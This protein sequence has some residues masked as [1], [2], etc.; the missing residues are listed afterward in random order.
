[1]SLWVRNGCTIRTKQKF[2]KIRKDNRLHMKFHSSVL[3]GIGTAILLAAS[4]PATP[5]LVLGETTFNFGAVPQNSKVSHVF[6]L[7]SA[8]EDTLQILK[9]VSGCGLNIAAVRFRSIGQRY[10][11]S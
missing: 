8:G 9:V 2:T 1:V 11:N 10:M 7:H 4:S 5:R 6:W 3:G